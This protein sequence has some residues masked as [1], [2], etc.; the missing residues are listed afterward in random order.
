MRATRRGPGPLT[1]SLARLL[2]EPHPTTTTTTNQQ[3]LT[4]SSQQRT[5]ATSARRVAAPPTPPLLRQGVACRQRPACRNLP[6]ADPAARAWVRVRLAAGFWTCPRPYCE[7]R[8]TQPFAS[9]QYLA[10][11]PCP[12][13]VHRRP[14][15]GAEYREARGSSAAPQPA[16]GQLSACAS[17]VHHRRAAGGAPM[18]ACSLAAAVLAPAQQSH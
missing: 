12:I 11:Q 6:S 10:T 2:A 17:T 14:A 3:Q 15:R 4:A 7:R 1:R 9:A 16:R 8:R 18:P 13:P 5:A